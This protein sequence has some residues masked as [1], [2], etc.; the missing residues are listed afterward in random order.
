MN[1]HDLG[2]ETF[3]EY[4]VV[5]ENRKQKISRWRN[6]ILVVSAAGVI[7]FE[8]VG[9]YLPAFRWLHG[10][11]TQPTT[12]VAIEKAIEEKGMR[13]TKESDRFPDWV[14]KATRPGR[15]IAY[16]IHGE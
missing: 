7:L 3:E 11:G 12:P 15:E 8:G 6:G 1:P 9:G 16:A 2:P 14:V 10:D 5:K 4:Q 13:L